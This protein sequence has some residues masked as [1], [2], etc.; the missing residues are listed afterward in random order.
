MDGQSGFPHSHQDQPTPPQTILLQ[1]LERPPDES[2]S[3][4][5]TAGRGA[6]QQDGGHQGAQDA[7]SRYDRLSPTTANMAANLPGITSYWDNNPY[8]QQSHVQGQGQGQGHQGTFLTPESPVDVSA[9]QSALP[10]DWGASL[11]RPLSEIS[12]TPTGAY[13]APAYFQEQV[14]QDSDRVPLT[15]TAQAIDG[16]SVAS[17]QGRDSFQTVR[18]LDTG[19]EPQ[20]ETKDMDRGLGSQKL[21]S[22]GRNLTAGDAEVD[23]RRSRS[24]STSGALLKAGSIMRAM[25]QRVVNI[26][27]EAEVLE[28]QKRR[29]RSRSP[30][31]DAPR[32]SL[33]TMSDSVD[34]SYPSQLY[35]NK[36]SPTE[37]KGQTEYIFPSDP[38][39]LSPVRG[40]MPNPLKG[41]SLGLF[42]P[43]NP[44]RTRLCDFLVQPWTE[45][46]I[47]IL[48][49]LQTILLCVEAASDVFE[50]PEGRPSHWGSTPIDW[51]L[52]VLFIIYTLEVIARIIV[53]GF[54]LNASEYSTI[55]RKR[56]VKA[57]V[58]EKYRE[59]FQPQR[60]KSVKKPPQ[61]IYGPSTL[62]RSV[63][64][65]HGQPLPE[66]LEE[67]QR[68]QLARRAFLRHGF[69]RLDFVAVVSFWISFVIGITGLE[70]EHHMYVFRMLSCLRI[71]R[72]LAITKGNAVS[73]PLV[74]EI[75][76]PFCMTDTP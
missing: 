29:E 11:T 51:A 71:L 70:K 59:V 8:H 7:G 44:I 66:T 22:F 68:Y 24:P 54:I 57:V 36:S 10:P 5:G 18:D 56:G 4:Q 25:S 75:S 35:G 45:P 53:S 50:D 39:P 63:T 43:D 37:K 3:Y 52:A 23:R 19:R 49:V 55:D 74:Y 67:Q 60:H 58:S 41:K 2:Q 28:A 12:T 6:A 47:L 38:G 17:D 65:L 48:I 20:R 46:L 34:T 31:A 72:L 42:S 9:F 14:P 61:D 73:S 40:R 76:V 1:N 13:E 32:V 15:S 21:K 62:A 30:S 64:W 69:N 16:L 26:S 33:P 27:G